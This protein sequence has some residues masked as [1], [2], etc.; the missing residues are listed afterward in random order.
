MNQLRKELQ[1][2]T[3]KES[4]IK[5][6]YYSLTAA[7]LLCPLP[8]HTGNHYVTIYIYILS[9]TRDNLTSI[10]TIYIQSYSSIPLVYWTV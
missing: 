2:H 4:T 5:Y 1:T 10:L 9:I 7:F 3:K 6:R 8:P